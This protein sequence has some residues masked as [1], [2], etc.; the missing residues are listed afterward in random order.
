MKSIQAKPEN[1]QIV[2]EI[3]TTFS[4]NAFTSELEDLKKKLE[5]YNFYHGFSQYSFQRR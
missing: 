2:L 4:D 3:S 5:K 1:I